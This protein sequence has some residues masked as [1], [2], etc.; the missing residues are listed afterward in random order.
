M[1]SL[2]NL[3]DQMA[4]GPVDAAPGEYEGPVTVRHKGIFDGHGATL[5]VAQGPALRIEA[6]GAVL[7]N[8]RVEV[9]GD[10][11]QDTAISGGGH[12][13]TF[14]HVEVHGGV[15]GVPGVAEGWSLPS[16]VELGAFSPQEENVAC[17]PLTLP[18]AADVTCCMDGVHV[19]PSHLAPGR[20]CLMLT[21]DG[22]RDGTI[23]YG[24]I[25]LQTG[26][27]IRRLYVNGRAQKGAARRHDQPPTDCDS[28][29]IP[30]GKRTN[31]RMQSLPNGE[32]PS[33]RGGGGSSVV[34]ST[35]RGQRLAVKD[36]AL[37]VRYEDG[38]RPA[39]L[40]IDTYIFT[41]RADGKTRSDDDLYFFGHRD[42]TAIALAEQPSGPD[43]AMITLSKVPEDVAHIIVSYAIYDE[44]TAPAFSTVRA[45]VVRV[46]GAGQEAVF[47]LSG[48]S[49]EK[50]VV[51]LDL[52]R[53]NG[54][55]KV[56]FV[57]AGYA[58]GLRRLCES[59]GMDVEGT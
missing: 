4:Q 28:N 19:A 33:L 9:V 29:H 17:V 51:A 43:V 18:E 41:L 44:G 50:T 49:V 27:L 14:E 36:D 26:G 15:T 58:A 34:L 5:W 6:D 25:L 39:G 24:S 21:I 20:A 38:G 31:A 53:K 30:E 42:G 46:T 16:G 22:M 2:Q 59:Y 12:A 55:W 45:P 32:V 57:G 52:Y 23:L 48:L 1:E 8:L 3:L 7:R 35:V 47:Q 56:H 11:A 37:T 13:V 40:D 54:A 10:P